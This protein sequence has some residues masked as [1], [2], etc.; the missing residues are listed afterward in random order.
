MLCFIYISM[1]QSREQ[2]IQDLLEVYFYRLDKFQL[3]FKELVVMS[4]KIEELG[5]IG[6]VNFIGRFKKKIQ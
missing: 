5:I 2:W 3:G 4:K 1:K 6:Y